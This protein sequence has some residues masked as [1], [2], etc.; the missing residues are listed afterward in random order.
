MEQLTG[1]QAI[2]HREIPIKKQEGVFQNRNPEKPLPV[3]YSPGSWMMPGTF[4]LLYGYGAGANVSA[5]GYG[6]IL[7][8]RC[9][10]AKQFARD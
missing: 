8:A 7:N 1:Y 5:G 9:K 2:G 10:S 4:Y 6:Y 3:I